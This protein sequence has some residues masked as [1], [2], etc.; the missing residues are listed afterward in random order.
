MSAQVILSATTV[1]NP[2][3]AI[4]KVFLE[5]MFQEEEEAGVCVCVSPSQ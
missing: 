5:L 4:P 1:P 2:A 3:H